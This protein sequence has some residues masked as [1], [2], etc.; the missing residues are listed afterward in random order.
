MTSSQCHS[1]WSRAGWS[2]R[3]HCTCRA[4][5]PPDRYGERGRRPRAWE[6]VVESGLLL[7]ALAELLEHG[8]EAGDR[9]L[10]DG[11]QRV[12]PVLVPGS[13]SSAAPLLVRGLGPAHWKGVQGALT[14]TGSPGRAP[15]RSGL[16][17]QPPALTRK[18]TIWLDPP[19]RAEWRAIPPGG[20]SP[21]SVGSSPRSR[22]STQPSDGNVHP[23][24]YVLLGV[25]CMER[26]LK[27][28]ARPP[29]SVAPGEGIGLSRLHCHPPHWVEALSLPSPRSML[30]LRYLI[31]DASPN[32][33]G[34]RAR[35][36]FY[37]RNPASR[38]G[39]NLPQNKQP[40]RGRARV[41]TRARLALEPKRLPPPPATCLSTSQASFI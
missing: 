37:I 5:D 8:A 7:V 21:D 23:C 11:A 31:T 17:P 15:S 33:R 32:H 26:L 3:P 12:A 19:P 13:L 22:R 25:P 16:G 28:R 9:A 1:S 35:H 24:M 27:P 18:P 2:P 6:V 14:Q 29:A 39:H 30:P 40:T 20:G 38:R 34:R 10:L 36:C 4:P 41:R